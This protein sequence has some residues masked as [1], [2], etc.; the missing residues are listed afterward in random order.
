MKTILINREFRLIKKEAITDADIIEEM[1]SVMKKLGK[2]TL[3]MKEFDANA[4][5]NSSTVVN[6]FGTWNNALV[7]IG[8]NINNKTHSYEELMRNIRDVWIT[9]GKQPSRRDMDDKE[10]SNISSGAYL[11]RY[12]TWYKAL[13]SFITYISETEDEASVDNPEDGVDSSIKH[14][15]KRDPSD[16]LKVQVLMRDGNRCRICGVECSGGL[17]NIHFDHIFP[18]S[19]GGETTLDNLQVLCSACNEAKGNL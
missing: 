11:R 19:K 1:K 13:E 7:L 9:K 15:T 2:T 18:W 8:A 3:T 10:L 6:H 4:K 16:R 17:H 12:G 14:K 5:F